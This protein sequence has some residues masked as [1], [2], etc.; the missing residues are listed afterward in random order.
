MKVPISKFID[1]TIDT[2][3]MTSVAFIISTILAVALGLFLYL[4]RKDGLYPKPLTYS[5]ASTIINF[6]RSTPFII[7]MLLLVPVTRFIIGTAIGTNAVIIAL[8]VSGVP[9]MARLVENSFLEI[10]QGVIEVAQSLGVTTKA[11]IFHFLL[12]EAASILIANLTI[13]AVGTIGS[14]A[15][16]GTIGGGG[17]GDLA[18]Q[19][20]Y[21][22]FDYQTM[23]LAVAILIVIVQV[24]Q[25]LGVFLARKAKRL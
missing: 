13:A 1:A 6:L 25:I 20:G 5:I 7:L 4:S 3:Y 15:V 17:L 19:F 14:T 9:Y 11:L 8:I 24:V 10:D 21:S 2:L 18:I 22:R 16:A 12:P 23:F